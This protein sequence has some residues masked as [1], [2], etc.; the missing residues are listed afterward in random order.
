VGILRYVY[1]FSSRDTFYDTIPSFYESEIHGLFLIDDF[2]GIR[3]SLM[4]FNCGILSVGCLDS[5]RR[6][7]YRIG[8]CRVNDDGCCYESEY[9]EDYDEEDKLPTRSDCNKNLNQ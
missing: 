6:N 8:F 5:V 4:D 2:G 9:Y 1:E 7:G 3:A